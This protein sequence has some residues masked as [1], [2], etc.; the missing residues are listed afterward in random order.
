MNLSKKYVSKVELD[1]ELCCRE[2]GQRIPS[3]WPSQ[4]LSVQF[5]REKIWLLSF[6]YPESNQVF[7]QTVFAIEADSDFSNDFQKNDYL[8]SLDLP[9]LSSTRE[10]SLYHF[11]CKEE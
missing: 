9:S 2:Q 6:E 4:A 1:L 8:G 10:K 7:H 5:I 3:G 11:F